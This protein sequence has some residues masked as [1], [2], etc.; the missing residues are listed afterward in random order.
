MVAVTGVSSTGVT[1]T[2]TGLPLQLGPLTLQPISDGALHMAPGPSIF[3]EAPAEEWQERVELDA[4]GNVELSMNCLLV[5]VGERRILVD[6]GYGFVAD[7][8]AVGHLA[9]GLAALD[10]SPAD[11]DTVIVS[12]AHGDHIGGATHGVGSEARPTFGN[13]RYW[14]GQADWDHFSQPNV[15]SA[16]AGLADK[17][18]P[19]KTA[20]VLNLADGEQE[21]APGIRLLPLPGHTPGHMGVAFTSGQEMAIYIGDLVHHPLQLEHPEW[22]PIFDALPPVSRET[23]VRLVERARAERALI[24][25]YH[26][27]YPGIGRITETG[28]QRA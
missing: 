3:H 11:I 9:N 25:S 5:R 18:F 21:V 26:L 22:C 2:H 6:T 13:A 12:H 8:P 20:E 4:H 7:R 14:L 27:P 16:R 23:R 28:W 19:L 24:L 1:T 15:L 10:V 17:L